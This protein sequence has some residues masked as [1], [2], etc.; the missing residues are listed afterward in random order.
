MFGRPNTVLEAIIN[1]RALCLYLLIVAAWRR[2]VSCTLLEAVEKKVA[3]NSEGIGRNG[4][5]T[6]FYNL[7]HPIAL[8][9]SLGF[10]VIEIS[11]LDL[12]ETAECRGV[13]GCDQNENCEYIFP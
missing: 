9:S 2:A 10:E 5:T 7:S 6:P 12:Y 1:T 3:D 4:K 11:A 8:P 13:A